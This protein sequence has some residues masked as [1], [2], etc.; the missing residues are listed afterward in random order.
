MSTP[1]QG[2]FLENGGRNE[3]KNEDR[4]ALSPQNCPPIPIRESWDQHGESRG[5]PELGD[6]GFGHG[7]RLR[8][9]GGIGGVRVGDLDHGVPFSDR[10]LR[11]VY[12]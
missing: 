8:V 11:S 12:F 2:T 3:D 6:D 10:D 1:L 9:R 4:T 7:D 5:L